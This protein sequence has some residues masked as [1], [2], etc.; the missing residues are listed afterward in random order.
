MIEKGDGGRK[1]ERGDGE[2]EI[3]REEGRGRGEGG[4]GD[5]EIEKGDGGKK[6]ER[7]EGERGEEER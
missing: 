5:I 3:A 7:V 6:G 4:K 1:G 2:T